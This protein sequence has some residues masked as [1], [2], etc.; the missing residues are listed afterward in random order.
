MPL[1]KHTNA[2]EYANEDSRTY[3]QEIQKSRKVNTCFMMAV[4]IVVSVIIIGVFLAVLMRFMTSNSEGGLGNTLNKLITNT[5][6]FIRD[7]F[8]PNNNHKATAGNDSSVN[9]SS[10]QPYRIFGEGNGFDLKHILSVTGE[11][12]KE[13]NQSVHKKEEDKKNLYHVN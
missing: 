11:V 2:F 5:T 13:V 1:H 10:T 8:P 3:F 4:T 7:A 6:N 9:A 12:I